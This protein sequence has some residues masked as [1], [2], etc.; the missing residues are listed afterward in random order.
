M[1]NIE[2]IILMIFVLTYNDP[3]R[4]CVMKMGKIM[5]MGIDVLIIYFLVSIF[6]A[7]FNRVMLYDISDSQVEDSSYVWISY[8]NRNWFYAFAT[9]LQYF[10]GS[11]FPNFMVAVNVTSSTTHWLVIIELFLNSSILIAIVQSSL[12]FYYQSFYVKSLRDLKEDKKLHFILYHEFV[13]D[14]DIHP[15]VLKYIVETHCENDEHD[16]STD[17]MLMKIKEKFENLRIEG[18]SA[19][20]SSEKFYAEN[21][22]KLNVFRKNWIWKIFLFLCDI[23]IVVLM[24]LYTD[25]FYMTISNDII[26]LPKDKDRMA[27]TKEINKNLNILYTMIYIT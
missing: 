17:E 13:D 2:D 20:K 5:S 6:Y 22:Q 21:F 26:K 23:G 16:F 18:S 7:C 25:H 4:A 15:N 10:P 9:I 24:V 14:N 1:G 27:V 19:K 8:G 3:I 12:Y 11:N